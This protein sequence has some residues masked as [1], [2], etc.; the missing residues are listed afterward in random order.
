MFS[1]SYKLL[2]LFEQ[3]CLFVVC[4]FSVWK[5]VNKTDNCS[6]FGHYAC[7]LPHCYPGTTEHWK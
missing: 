3:F 7:L 4:L 1:E 2:F 5:T 6:K